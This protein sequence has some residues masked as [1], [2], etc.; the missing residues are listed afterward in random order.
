M[1]P[2]EASFLRRDAPCPASYGSPGVKESDIAA[3]TIAPARV[4]PASGLSDA[5]VIRAAEVG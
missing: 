5:G 3:R 2:P 1:F 4:H